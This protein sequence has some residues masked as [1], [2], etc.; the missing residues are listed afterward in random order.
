MPITEVLAGLGIYA[1]VA[2]GLM[3]IAKWFMARAEKRDLESAIFNRA[4]DE[5]TIKMY[6]SIGRVD[7]I[8]S[9][10]TK[11]TPEDK[12]KVLKDD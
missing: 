11:L 4:F 6:E 7:V 10:G 5:M 12:R 3:E 2:L 9:D 8:I 1:K